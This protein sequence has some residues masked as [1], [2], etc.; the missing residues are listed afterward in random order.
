MKINHNIPALNAYRNLYQNQMN[1]SKNLEK[2]SSGLRINRAAD[3]A[4]GL[5]ISEK[6]RSQI[7]GLN[8]AERNSLDGISL[9]Q[10]AEGAMTEVHSM[11]QRMRELSVQAANDTNTTSDRQAIQLEI[12][13]LNLEID[14]IAAKT[15]FNTRKLL[16]GSSAADTQFLEGEMEITNLKDVPKVVDPSLQTGRYEVGVVSDP[17]L[18]YK[19]NQPG[20][21]VSSASVISIGQ[22]TIDNANNG[23]NLTKAPKVIRFFHNRWYLIQ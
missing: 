6:M 18:T 12:D 23:A 7:R 22:S 5:A 17:E 21:G 4:A 13:Q 15:E 11:L 8:Q 14:S 20:A 10:T 3:D 16:D 9:M 2:L 1:T 19:L